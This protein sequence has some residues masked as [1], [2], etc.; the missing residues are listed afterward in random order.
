MKGYHLSC[1][2]D[3]KGAN[4]CTNSGVYLSRK[5]AEEVIVAGY[6]W[7]VED[8][9]ELPEHTLDWLLENDLVWLEEIEIE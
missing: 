2:Y 4:I 6:D 9:E 1:E 5:K 3:F 7:S 8:D